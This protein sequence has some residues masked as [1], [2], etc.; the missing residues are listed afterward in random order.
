MG[1]LL[2]VPSG[3]S[4]RLLATI[5]GLDGE[6]ESVLGSVS[7]NDKVSLSDTG[8]LDKGLSRTLGDADE[9]PIERMV[10]YTTNN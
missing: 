10:R 9:I 7:L 4:V 3:V 2:K 1:K 6:A 8:R 5:C